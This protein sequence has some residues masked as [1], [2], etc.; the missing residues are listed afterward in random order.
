MKSLIDRLLDEND[1][2]PIVLYTDEGEE[3]AFEQVAVIPW[4]EEGYAILKPVV[5]TEGM[6]EEEALVFKLA[7]E[8]GEGVLIIEEDDATVDAVFG[9]YY[10]MLAA[11]NGGAQ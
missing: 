3:I 5:P 10:K 11:Y 4:Q 2:A 7:L 8:D 6:T 9:E 1:S